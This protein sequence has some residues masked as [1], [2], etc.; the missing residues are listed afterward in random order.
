LIMTKYIGFTTM[1]TCIKTIY[2]LIIVFG[3]FLNWSC[4]TNPPNPNLPPNTT[5]ANIPVEGDTLFALVTLYWDGGDDDG[6]IEGYKYRYIT[7]GLDSVGSDSFQIVETITQPWELT[8]ETSLT[9]SFNSAYPLNRQ[10]F[11]VSAVDN[12]GV[13]DPTPA[14][15]VFY[16]KMTYYPK[17]YILAPEDN[18]NLFYLTETTDWWSGI[19]LIFTGSDQDGEIVEYGYS[20]D[21][22]VDDINWIWTN[23]TSLY[24]TP[25]MFRQP[26]EGKHTI[27]VTA[28]DNTNLVDPE[29]SKVTIRL[30]EPKFDRDI[31]IIDET[32]E[33]GGFR[34]N[35]KFTDEEIDE[36]YADIFNS[37]TKNLTIS[38][39]DF[40]QNDTLPSL[41]TLAHYKAVFWY[42]DGY[43]KP[44]VLPDYTDYLEDYMNIGGNLILSGWRIL[45]AFQWSGG[46]EF[47]FGEGS[48]IHD[49]LHI[50]QFQETGRKPN[51]YDFIGLYGNGSEFSDL[52]VDSL[53]LAQTGD[54]TYLRG[55]LSHINAITEKGVFTQ[56]LY[57]YR[58]SDNNGNPTEWEGVPCVIRY[59]GTSFNTVVVGLPIFFL[60]QE[61]ARVMMREILTNLG[62]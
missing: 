33:N 29:G 60:K 8:T 11:Q 18:Q 49:Y 32:D 6:Y 5:I 13:V 19:S 23:D 55:K 45:T 62:F 59:Y 38:T 46:P 21:E 35:F 22:E 44:N 2:I 30:I 27:R 58:S 10:I 16:T 15:R 12:D 36:F 7:E 25:D 1:K 52:R 20:I 41:D 28:R 39:W 51:E 53:K 14:E 17:T 56:T 26:L 47:T 24:I 34:Y 50:N 31:L 42:A 61:D 9:I 48:F 57:T 40:V 54:R 3:V 4:K 37:Y 43:L